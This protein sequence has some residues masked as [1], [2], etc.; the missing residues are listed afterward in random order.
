MSST[1]LGVLED[2]SALPK[3][4]RC[5]VEVKM[6]RNQATWVVYELSPI[7]RMFISNHPGLLRFDGDF[8]FVPHALCCGAIDTAPDDPGVASLWQRNR[9]RMERES[10][11]G[12]EHPIYGQLIPAAVDVVIS[13]MHTKLLNGRQITLTRGE[14]A[15]ILD[16]YRQE[17]EKLAVPVALVE[18]RNQ[19]TAVSSK[20]KKRCGQKTNNPSGL[21]FAHQ[22][23]EPAE[24]L[25]DLRQVSEPVAQVV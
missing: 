18:T 8:Y 12:E 10:G 6:R 9:D 20:T 13:R 11:L 25:P 7:N 5:R 22:G 16:F 24:S 4:P 2:V 19:C 3:C 23:K 1:T 17:I 21:C 15:A 14:A